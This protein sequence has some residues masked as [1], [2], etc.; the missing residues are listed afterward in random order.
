MANA[1]EQ[2]AKATKIVADTGDL[3]RYSSHLSSQEPCPVGL[4][5]I[6]RRTASVSSS[7]KTRPPTRH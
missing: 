4:N 1:R 5:A 7:P 6:P 3:D 2:L